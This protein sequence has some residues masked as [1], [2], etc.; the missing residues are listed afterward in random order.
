MSDFPSSSGTHDLRLKVAAYIVA[1]DEEDINKP[2][3][4]H[5][6]DWATTLIKAGIGAKHAGDCTKESYSCMRC[7]TDRA[8]AHA[9]EVLAI[10]GVAHAQPQRDEFIPETCRDCGERDPCDDD[11][12]NFIE[13]PAQ[14][15]G[16][17][18]EVVM[19]VC[20]VGEPSE[21]RIRAW[22]ADPK[23]MESLRAEGLD[24]RPLYAGPSVVSSTHSGGAT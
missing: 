6:I 5:L 17:R 15:A 7:A 1:R 20:L 24:M 14:G 2:V 16:D 10:V 8:F 22:T 23:R 13:R 18:G 11:C 9:D 19:W 12:P 4:Q 21:R 3:S